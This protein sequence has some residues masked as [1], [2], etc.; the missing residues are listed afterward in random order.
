M[1]YETYSQLM[2]QAAQHVEGDKDYN[3]ALDV[4]ERLLQSDI[5]DLDKAAVCHNVAVLYDKVGQVEDA[6]AWYDEGIA[7]EQPYFRYHV[8]H[9]KAVYLAQQG[10]FQD[11]L[12]LFEGLLSQPGLMEKEKAQIAKSIAAVRHRLGR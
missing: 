5:S 1:E 8:A 10:R 3:A 11:S 4:F 6:L 9:K 7:Y 2:Q 12:E